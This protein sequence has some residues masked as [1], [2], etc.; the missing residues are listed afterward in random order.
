MAELFTGF[1][2]LLRTQAVERQRRQ[3]ILDRQ[4]AILQANQGRRAAGAAAGGVV[5]EIINQAVLAAF[6]GLDPDMVRAKQTEEAINEARQL[7]DVDAF[8]TLEDGTDNPFA[9]IDRR[10]ALVSQSIGQMREKGLHQEADQLRANLAQLR[11]ERLERRQALGDIE[12]QDVQTDLRRTELRIRSGETSGRDELTRLLNQLETLDLDDPEEAARADIIRAR[13]DKI[14]EITG[15][16]EFDVDDKTLFRNSLEELQTTST[17]LARL[18]SMISGYDPTFLQLEGKVKNFALNF[19]DIAGLKLPPEA[20]DQLAAYKTFQARTQ[21]NLNLYI[22][23]ITGAQMNREEAARL[24]AS[25]PNLDDG[26][27]AFVSKLE[28]TYAILQATQ[29]RAEAIALA[30]ASGDPRAKIDARKIDIFARGQEIAESRRAAKAEAA[31]R[32][33]AAI[34]SGVEQLQNGGLPDLSEEEQSLV[35]SIL[36]DL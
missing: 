28:D 22:R 20:K 36:G 23:E 8:S 15:R 32:A 7:V 1:E 31:A 19:A 11:S 27:T 24:T 29:E 35:D 16:T 30:D 12:S 4:Q 21:Q 18:D 33:D 9:D 26:P 10:M 17:Q 25:Q 2:G 3:E 13:L 14:T 5:G 6:P 34:N